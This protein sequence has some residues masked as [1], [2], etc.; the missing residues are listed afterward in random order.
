M[1]YTYDLPCVLYNA[2]TGEKIADFEA[3]AVTSNKSSGGFTAGGTPSGGQNFEIATDFVHDFEPNNERV[4]VCG[5]T[6][7]ITAK[8]V[9]T[10]R[11][12]G[13]LFREKPKS[14]TVLELQ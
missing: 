10:E 6:F 12:C 3:R 13:T 7:I 1:Q 14:E 5:Q 2:E 9:I 4:A 11:R 8:R